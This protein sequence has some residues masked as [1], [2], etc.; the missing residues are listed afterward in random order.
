[1]KLYHTIRVGVSG[2]IKVPSSLPEEL[3]V[4]VLKDKAFGS[5]K[6]SVKEMMAESK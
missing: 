4:Y 2:V 6:A 3:A 1:M 5:F